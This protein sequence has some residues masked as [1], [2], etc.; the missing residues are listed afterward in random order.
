MS[1]EMCQGYL[2]GRMAEH[3]NKQGKNQ[4][5]GIWIGLL[6]IDGRARIVKRNID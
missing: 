4:T 6:G 2:K 1:A 5:D 3:Y